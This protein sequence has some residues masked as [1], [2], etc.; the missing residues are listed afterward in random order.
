MWA[1]LRWGS[2]LERNSTFDEVSRKKN[3]KAKHVLVINQAEGIMVEGNN[4][5]KAE[6][7]PKGSKKSG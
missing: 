2:I 6:G 5:G 3:E 4:N 7:I 1:L